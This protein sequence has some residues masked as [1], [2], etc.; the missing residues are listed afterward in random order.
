M[1]IACRNPY[2]VRRARRIVDLAVIRW[3]KVSNF[4]D[5][6][7]LAQVPGVTLRYVGR[8]EQFGKPD[9]VLLPGTKNVMG[10]LA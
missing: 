1:R 5:F 9:L 8:P 10:D 3:P 4:T 6:Q 7:P 2:P